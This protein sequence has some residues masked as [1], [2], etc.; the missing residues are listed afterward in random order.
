MT[1]AMTGT[2]KEPWPRSDRDPFD[3][4]AEHPAFG[5]VLLDRELAADLRRQVAQAE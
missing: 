4:A 2:M 5:V 1:E 3:L